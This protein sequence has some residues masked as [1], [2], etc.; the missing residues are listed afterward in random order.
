ML[1]VLALVSGAAERASAELLS[2]P[3]WGFTFDPPAGFSLSDG[4][5]KNRFVFEDSVSSVQVVLRAYPGGTYDSCEAAVA[6]AQKRLSSEGDFSPFDYGRRRAS[7]GRLEFGVLGYPAS[8]WALCA[9][10]DA[11]GDG[12]AP[13]LLLVL[14]YG[15]DDDP[16]AAQV[17]LSVLD[18]FSFGPADS[19]MSGPI[20]SF[21]YPPKGEKRVAIRLGDAE[22]SAVIDAGDQE[23][24]KAVVD[25]EFAVLSAYGSSP[26]WKEA[27]TRFYRM[28]WRDAWARLDSVAFAATLAA[29][30]K[31]PSPAAGAAASGSGGAAARGETVGM[32][33]GAA[34]RAAENR[35]LAEALLGWVQGFRYERDL[36]GSD[37]VD[38]VSCAVEGRGDCDS[39]SMLLALVLRK[40]NI[41]AILM[42]SRDYGHAMAGIDLS[43]AGARF[44]FDGGR[45]IVAETTDD[46]ALGLIGQSVSDP[47]KWLGIRFP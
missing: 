28:I 8:G 32:D 38:L 26:L 2:S 35:A 31:G 43:G 29:R 44:P 45:W 25:R 12:G 16:S 23:A 3:T 4:D 36:M 41:D 24:A 15:K 20:A 37:F 5:G 27:W 40:A 1:L 9:E 39:R 13:P 47:G 18:S 34:A 21:A 10:L 17:V 46:V 19:L 14:V 6:D 33:S 11:P 22:E 42:V 30:G 7:L